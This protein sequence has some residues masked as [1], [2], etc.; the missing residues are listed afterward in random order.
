MLTKNFP[1]KRN[2]RRISALERLEKIPEDCRHKEDKEQIKTLKKRI[3]S[4]EDT[5]K[6]RTKKFRGKKG[7]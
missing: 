3:T 1:N 6:I 4:E 2:K 5:L 7:R